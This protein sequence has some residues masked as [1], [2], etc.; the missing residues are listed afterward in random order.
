MIDSLSPSDR[1]LLMK[2]ACAFAWT[3]LRVDEAERQFI[4]RLIVRLGLEDH[5]GQ[6]N[7]WLKSPPREEDVDPTRVPP[8]HRQLFLD[9]AREVFRA[10]G[11]VDTFEQEQFALLEE[12][13]R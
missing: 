8:E 2:F 4:D 3:D 6:V 11:V 12:L 5:R 1:L 13:L 9:A 10:D 7:N